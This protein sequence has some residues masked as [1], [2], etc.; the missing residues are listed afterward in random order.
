MSKCGCICGLEKA[1]SAGKFW[2]GIS[3]SF[4]CA[5]GTATKIFERWKTIDRGPLS[6]VMWFDWSL[7]M[8]SVDQYSRF[9]NATCWTLEYLLIF[10]CEDGNYGA[11][12]LCRR[13]GAWVFKIC[14]VAKP[15]SI[16]YI[17]GCFD[18]YPAKEGVPRFYAPKVWGFAVGSEYLEYLTDGPYAI[19]RSTLGGTPC[20]PPLYVDSWLGSSL[21]MEYAMHCSGLNESNIRSA[22]L[23]RFPGPLKT[24]KPRDHWFF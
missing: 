11:A 2:N 7:Y 20:H 6:A 4:G 5:T 1:G 22:K 24:L 3:K 14:Y 13:V 10:S 16:G 8:P 12:L 18:S 17:T 21:L 23:K 19:P 15:W 9:A